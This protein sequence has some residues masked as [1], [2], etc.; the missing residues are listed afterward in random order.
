MRPLDWAVLITTLVSIVAY[1]LYRS[2]GSNTVDRYLLAGKT[3]PWYAMGLSIMATQASAVTFISTTGQAY[4]DGM[5]FV[6]F[7]FGLP[8]A[9]V[10][11]CATVVPV[12]H[13]AKVYTAYEYLE[14]RFDGKTRALASIVFLCQRGLS[15]GITIYAP[16]IVLSVILGWPERATTSLMGAIVVTYT[17]LGGIKAVTWSDVQQMCVIFLGLVIALITVFTLL[18]GPV[19]IPDAVFLAGAAG[20]LNAVTTHFSWADRFNIWSGLLG[21]TFLFLS[22]FGCDQSQVQRYLT[23]KSIAESRL[24]L[25]FNAVA[26]I[27]MQFFILFIGA[28]VFVFYLFVQPPV[29]FQRQELARIQGAGQYRAIEAQYNQAF[30][31]RRAAAL[32]LTAAHRAGDRQAEAR[33]IADYRAAQQD[34]DGARKL[35][36]NLVTRMG[37][38]KDFSDTNYIFLSFVTRYLPAGIVGLVI[39]VIFAATMSASSGEINSLATVTVMDIYKRFARRDAS[40]H[41]Y[42]MASRWSTLFWG[43][44]AVLFAGFAG[45]LGSLIVAVNFVG[46]LFYGT[47]LGCFAL[48][49]GFRGVGGTAAFVGMLTGE[50]AVLATAYFTNI[51]WLWYNGIGAGVVVLTALT[52][53]YATKSAKAGT[54]LP[55]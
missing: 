14:N 52:F 40:D 30:T 5:R 11:I 46:S 22:Y 23:G 34:L 44:Y 19:S 42:L 3:M 55:E 38:E 7:Y 36:S 27:P 15:A 10:V 1:G 43:I 16:A 48:A 47:L 32:A 39:A 4:V 13:R 37:G 50:A 28:M 24:S 2:R 6:Q 8:I 20:R 18:P 25:L 31:H 17:V 21:G 9:M 53:A 26:K 29:L 54:P 51:S 35:A 12:F 49:L 33:D 45:R 41:H